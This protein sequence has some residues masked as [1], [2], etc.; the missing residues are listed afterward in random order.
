MKNTEFE[1]WLENRL[2]EFPGNH[3]NPNGNSSRAVVSRGRWKELIYQYKEYPKSA[4][5]EIKSFKGLDTPIIYFI[6]LIVILLLSPIVPIVWSY[7]S[8]NSAIEEFK[9]IFETE[10]KEK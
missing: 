3:Y 6:N 4:I 8:Y 2:K 1:E 7:Y 10:K 9:H 5:Y